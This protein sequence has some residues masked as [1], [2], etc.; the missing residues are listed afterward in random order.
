MFWDLN[1]A[2]AYIPQISVPGYPVP[3]LLSDVQSIN[4]K[5]ISWKPSKG[6]YET[7]CLVN[8]VHNMGHI[9]DVADNAIFSTVKNWPPTY[10]NDE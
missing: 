9:H 5:F 1:E 10:T 7:H 6:G 8:Y 3:F 4:Q 2:N